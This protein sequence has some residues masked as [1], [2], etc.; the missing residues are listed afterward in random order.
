M[1]DR[2]TSEHS[3]SG[4]EH[5]HSG[6]GWLIAR[7]IAHRG[8]HDAAAGVIENSIPAAEA[9]IEPLHL[10]LPADALAAARN[11]I[12]GLASPRVALIPG[13]ARGPSKQWP[14]EHFIKLGRMLS[15]QKKCGILVLGISR[16]AADAYALGTQQR[17]AVEI[18]FSGDIDQA[19]Q[20][21]L[22]DARGGG[23]GGGA[24]HHLFK[25]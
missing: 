10:E 7:P 13:A 25:G 4:N 12:A 23:Q 8:L 11:R 3:P 16:E 19:R 17:A 9:A 18:L 14:R 24:G 20:H 21:H 1:R 2:S 15:E 5:A 22:I 6:L